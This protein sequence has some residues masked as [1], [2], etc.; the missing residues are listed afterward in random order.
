MHVSFVRLN[1][2]IIASYKVMGF[3]VLSTIL[4][5]LGSYIATYLFYLVDRTWVQPAVIS[6]SDERVLRLR[7]QLTAQVVER[8]HLLAEREQLLAQAADANQREAMEQT[9]QAQFIA[10][11]RADKREREQV[12][13]QLQQLAD[14]HGAQLT[15]T[16]V[17][18]AAAQE[19]AKQLLAAHVI[20]EE[21]YG[22]RLYQWSSRT[23]S[24]LAH[25]EKKFDFA[26]RISNLRREL[27]ALQETHQALSYET[28]SKQREYARS[29]LELARASHDQGRI[30]RQL[31]GIDDLLAQ[32]EA[33]IKTISLAPMLQAE[34]GAMVVAFV[35]YANAPYV[36]A[37]KP[38]YSCKMGLLWCDRVGHISAVYAGEAL[39]K[40]PMRKE[41]MRGITI[42]LELDEGAQTQPTLHL[43]R[44]AWPT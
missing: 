37:G 20:D 6:P 23:R 35:P 18:D 40:H 19:R 17:G 15:D 32:Y 33:L 14:A 30:A 13:A 9:F 12:L 31:S 3:V 43:A 29:Q 26:T 2:L 44:W 10:T 4:W 28:L 1:R 42:R 16:P 21:A 7:A 8:E 41:E 5:G 34:S 22:N 39:G 38:V 25:V 36:A 11:S 24:D 27:D